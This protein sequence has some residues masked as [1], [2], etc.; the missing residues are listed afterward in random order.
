MAREE[1]C[2]ASGLLASSLID[3]SDHRL[4]VAIGDT[5]S[6]PLVGDILAPVLASWSLHI[7]DMQE[8]HHVQVHTSKVRP[9]KSDS[10]GECVQ[11]HE[12]GDELFNA[13]DYTP[14]HL[15]EDDFW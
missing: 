9:A 14:D 5:I 7:R 10:D 15:K 4:E 11:G 2:T 1:K 6:P 8:K 3:L 12:G 13:M